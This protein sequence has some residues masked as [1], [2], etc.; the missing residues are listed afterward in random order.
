[1]F[2]YVI[3]NEQL[4]LDKV[5]ALDLKNIYSEENKENLHEDL[6]DWE[7]AVS[8]NKIENSSNIMDEDQDDENDFEVNN[9]NP[10]INYN[11]YNNYNQNNNY[12]PNVAV[13]KKPVAANP[14]PAPLK[15]LRR[16][17]SGPSLISNQNVAPAPVSKPTKSKICVAVRK[18][19]LNQQ[20]I[21]RGD[22]DILEYINECTLNVHEP[23]FVAR[24]T[25]YTTVSQTFL[26]ESK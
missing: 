16:A 3:E 23:K 25:F 6:F 20:E 11:N 9:Y 17:S 22:T 24:T 2:N 10:N 7:T 26:K 19:P 21:L 13:D 5:Q 12:N 1:M 8:R 18:R 4:A 14:K 15:N